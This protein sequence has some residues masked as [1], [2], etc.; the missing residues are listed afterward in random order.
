VKTAYSFKKSL[1]I[2]GLSLSETLTTT[3]AVVAAAAAALAASGVG[4]AGSGSGLASQTAQGQSL[5]PSGLPQPGTGNKALISSNSGPN[6]I[7]DIILFMV[8]IL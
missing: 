6:Q 5:V 7:F 1:I 4:G 8:I 3:A 2:P